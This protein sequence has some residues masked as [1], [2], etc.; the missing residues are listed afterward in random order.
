MSK[1]VIAY[2]KTNDGYKV[3]D[4]FQAIKLKNSLIKNKDE[5]IIFWDSPNENMAERMHTVK[6]SKNGRGA[7]FSYYPHSVRAGMGNDMSM[8]HRLYCIALSE[9]K[10]LELYHFG[11]RIKVYV[12]SANPEVYYRTKYNQYY[13]DV[14]IILEKTEP[15]SYFYKWGGRLVIEVWVSHK[16][17]RS[18]A[19]DLE[20]SGLQIFELKVYPNQRIPDDICSEQEYNDYKKL[21]GERVKHDKLVGR[22]INNVIPET[23]TLMGARYIQLADYEKEIMAFKKR[24]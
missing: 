11:E 2:C 1:K 9:E 7:H 18:K 20:K 23:E 3:I 13:L 10:V 15:S 12:A 22:M 14:M 17:D 24:N 4:I 16:V 19:N 6:T 5:D 21:I 8:T